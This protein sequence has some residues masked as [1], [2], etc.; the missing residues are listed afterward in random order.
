MNWSSDKTIDALY[1]SIN[2][3]T[4]WNYISNPNA[5]SGSYTI[6]NLV[7]NTTYSIV[8]RMKS[9]DSQLYGNSSAMNIQTYD[10]ARLQDLAEIIHGNTTEIKATNPANRYPLNLTILINETEVI[11]RNIQSLPYN[12]T[13]TVEES[14]AIYRMYGMN[15]QLQ[16][17]VILT[18]DGQYTD[19]LSIPF[20]YKGNQRTA[21]V[22]I[23]GSIKRGKISVNV[24]GSYKRATSWTK[25]AGNWKRGG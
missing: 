1:Y 19:E 8:T 5:A 12:L 17:T 24:G 13:P 3:G 21:K 18:A 2:G 11:K 9:R 10:I 14:D 23:E 22:N 20:I 16:S 6:S 4:T 25:I 7:P 15:Q